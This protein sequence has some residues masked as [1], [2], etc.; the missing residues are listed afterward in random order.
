MVEYDDRPIQH[1]PEFK[2]PLK[3]RS[4]TDIPCLLIFV[5]FI[6]CWIAIGLFALSSGDIETLL[7]PKDSEGRKCGVDSEMS[8]KSYLLFFDLTKCDITHKKC[9][10]P[11]VCLEKCPTENWV[12]KDTDPLEDIRQKIICKPGVDVTNK[13]RTHIQALI[14][15]S[16][17]APMYLKSKSVVNRC[18]PTDFSA[19]F[20]S[21][22]ILGKLK[23]AEEIIGYLTYAQGVFDKVVSSYKSALGIVCGGALMCIIYMFLLKWLALP[24]VLIAIFGVCGLFGYLGYLSYQS[25]SETDSSAWLIVTII[26]G[27]VAGII[28]LLTVCLWQRIYLACQLI[29]EASKAVMSALSSLFF[30]ILPWLTHIAI[31]VYFFYIGFLLI[32]IGDQ[33][34]VI[35]QSPN[36]VT[37]NCVCPSWLNYN[38]NSSCDP[39]LFNSECRENAEMCVSRACH[40]RGVDNPPYMK[41]MYLIHIFG[42]LWLYFFISALG[43]MTLAATFATWYWTMNKSDVPFFTVTV[44][45]WRTIRYHLG[46]VAF[47]SLLITIC[48]FFRIVLEY[49][50]R[51]STA[52]GGGQLLGTCGT[53]IYRCTQCIMVLLEKFLKFMNRN[54]YIVCAVYGKGLCASA[55]DALSLL[56]RNILRVV[57]LNKIVDWL[58]F[59]G[60]ILVT[61]TMIAI[62][63]WYYKEEEGDNEFWWVPTI[64]VGLGSYLVASVFFSV[65]ATAVDTIFLCFLEDCE[66]HDG[67]AE[68]PYY[69]SRKIAKLL[70][71]Q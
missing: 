59:A 27:S 3:N 66:R 28:A 57:I 48:R 64:L 45:L 54:A 21:D 37:D 36:V 35:E 30:P 9:Y 68:K 2:G 47:G 69:M 39:A 18:V 15:V 13:D 49:I 22:A 16:A 55:G 40:L 33:E 7:A 29:K 20:I 4:C 31:I 52:Q 1:D 70:N 5:A 8:N 38:I 58:L 60:K 53:A 24:C 62:S 25:Y 42:G 44:S 23:Q 41:W 12:F 14:Y 19:D 17:C 34:F 32:S 51:Q 56:M 11:Q 61:C 65:H 50:H 63:W 26:L 71:L 6:V 67:S 43:E 46:T 10:T